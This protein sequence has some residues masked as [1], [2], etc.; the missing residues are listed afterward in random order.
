MSFLPSFGPFAGILFVLTSRLTFRKSDIPWMAAAGLSAWAVGAHDGLAGATFGL[1]QVLGPWAVYR[2]F[3]EIRRPALGHLPGAHVIEGLFVGFVLLVIFGLGSVTFNLSYPTITQAI[4]WG[5]NPTLFAHMVLVVGTIIA[6]LSHQGW[7]RFASIALAVLAITAAGSLEAAFGL[8]LVVLFLTIKCAIE[9]HR[10]QSLGLATLGGVAVVLIAVGPAIGFGRI[11]YL[12]TSAPDS[13]SAN[14]VQGSELPQGDWWDRREVVVHS[15]QVSLNG[16]PMTLYRVTKR[17][18]AGWQRLQQVIPLEA[19]RTYTVSAW[20]EGG[21][22]GKPGIQGWGKGDGPT[23]FAMTTQ[24]QSGTLDAFLE[25]HGTLH[26]FGIASTDGSWKRIYTTFTYT[27][28]PKTL[29]WYV[30]LAPDARTVANSEASFAGFQLERG[31]L[32]QYQPGRATRGLGLAVGRMTMWSAAFDGFDRKP[33][34]GWGAGAFPSFFAR[35]EAGTRL[36]GM[37]TPAHAHDL[38]LEVAFERGAVGLL[39]L[40]LLLVGLTWHAWR[41]R[42]AGFLVV[43]LAV[44]LANVFDYTLYFGGVIYPLVA[45]AGWR[46]GDDTQA[47]SAADSLSKRFVVR[48]VL[49]ATDLGLAWGGFVASKL[50]LATLGV[51]GP[52]SVSNLGATRFAL[53]LWPAMVWREG[54]YPGYGL[55]E[56]DELKRQVLSACYAGSLFLVAILL[57]G[58]ELKV[59]PSIAVGTTILTVLILPV[60]RAATKRAL[61]AIGLWGRPVVILGSGPSVANIAR[62]LDHR[63]LDG[64][65][66]VAVFADRAP[67]ADEQEAT[68]GMVPVIGPISAANTFARRE[69]IHHAI[70]AMDPHSDPPHLPKLDPAEDAFTI[71]QYVPDL[72]GLPVLGVRASPLDNL[73]ALEVRNELASP[74]NRFAKRLLDIVAAV[75]GGLAI[76]PVLLVLGLAVVLDSRGPVFFGHTRIGRNG[77]KI[78]VW[79]FR[80]MVR[81]AQEALERHLQENPELRAEWEATH[82]LK[83]DPRVTRVGRFLRRFSLDELPQLWN[84]LEGEMSLVGPRPIVDE[85]VPK[86]ADAFD[87][88]T[89]VRPGM[90]GYWQISGRSDT[91]Y[92]HRVELDSFYVRNWSVWLDIV[93]LIKTVSAVLKRDGAY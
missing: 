87:L 75:L 58:T 13:R 37:E 93:V 85:E 90:T 69:G 74:V 39:S 8:I 14:L 26:A 35:S 80:T 73:L 53:L 68:V 67:G 1:L 45:I 42:D 27:G 29:D 18:N 7:I 44:L 66:P 62:T 6:L 40:V 59:V 76:S 92:D 41:R 25:G 51:G 2:A 61:R 70:V 71:V 21:G 72:P 33:W 48:L 64:L 60:G 88:Y 81:D 12:I 83:N 65:R 57:F 55:T 22:P 17:G 79:K 49:A 52:G 11:G 15:G 86:Y 56:P 5:A 19:G 9:G 30:G 34:L 4:V 38:F 16:K 89:M 54:L 77:R 32:T 78:R 47:T 50:L 36:R 20:V 63:S 43:L 82:K 91:D 24:L 31:P 84:V 28:P 10:A 23:A 46:S 3:A